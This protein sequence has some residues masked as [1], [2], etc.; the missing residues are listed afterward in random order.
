M[1]GT[2]IVA[3]EQLHSNRWTRRLDKVCS[4]EEQK[5]LGQAPQPFLAFA[6][7]WAMKEAA[8]KL[9]LRL[10]APLGYYPKKISLQA[11][12]NGYF[13]CP[14]WG[15]YVS[16]KQAEG[17]FWAQAAEQLAHFSQIHYEVYHWPE[18]AL[19]PRL[20]S[21]ALREELVQHLGPGQLIKDKKGL[22][23]WKEKTGSSLIPLSLSY[24]GPW[25]SWAR[26][27]PAAAYSS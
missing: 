22:P 7:L 18:L 10:G 2:D 11:R 4:L 17:Y 20:R 14:L 1:L 21:A 25:A 23:F 24:D 3:L 5:W 16:L 26:V 8:Y 15:V 6:Q 12:T 19:S 13:Y 27:V 9:G